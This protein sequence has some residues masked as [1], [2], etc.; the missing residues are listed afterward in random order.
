[1][2]RKLFAEA[3][4]VLPVSDRAIAAKLGVEPATLSRWISG[5]RVVANDALVKVTR[6]VRQHRRAVERVERRLADA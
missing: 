5:H 3:V 4:S 1:M 2:R 6:M